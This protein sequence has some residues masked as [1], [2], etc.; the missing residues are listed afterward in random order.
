MLAKW[1]IRFPLTSA[2]EIGPSGLSDRSLGLVANM[3]VFCSSV[4]STTIVSVT[5]VVSVIATSVSW[6]DSTNGRRSCTEVIDGNAVDVRN[7]SP[8]CRVLGSS[9]VVL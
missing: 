6:S 1:P 2:M 3:S 8:Y 7:R 5:V 9:V 4:V